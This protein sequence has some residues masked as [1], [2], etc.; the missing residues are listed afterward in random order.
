MSEL[1]SVSANLLAE[2]L[3]TFCPFRW[4]AL[5]HVT[6]VWSGTG[7]VFRTRADTRVCAR[8]VSRRV[9][10]SSACTQEWFL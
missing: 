8:Q 10:R 2:R 4:L 6:V 5:E 3:H 9:R 7:G 1:K